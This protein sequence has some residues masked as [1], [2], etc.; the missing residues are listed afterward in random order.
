MKVKFSKYNYIFEKEGSIYIYNTRSSAKIILNLQEE[1]DYF[2]SIKDKVLELDNFNRIYYDN[3]ILVDETVDE[4]KMAF[5]SG[6]QKMYDTSKLNLIIMPTR[7]CDLSCIYCYEKHEPKYMSE[8]TVI[9]VIN[10]IKNHYSSTKFQYLNIEWFGGEPLLAI[11]IVEQITIAL[12]KFCNSNNIIYY[13]SITTNGYSM[14]KQKFDKL[15]NLGIKNYQITI[16]GEK[17]IHDKLRITKE[18]YGSWDKIF[19]TFRLMK[20]SNYDFS[21]TVRIN[22]DM[23]VLMNLEK[24]IDFLNKQLLYDDRFKLL[25]HSIGDYGDSLDNRLELITQSLHSS[26]TKIINKML[27]SKNVNIEKHCAAMYCY[28]HKCYAS[29]Q[30]SLVIDYDGR[31]HKCT[32]LID[33]DI[34]NVGVVENNEFKYNL[35]KLYKWISPPIYEFN[36][37]CKTCKCFPTCFGGSCPISYVKMG[38]SANTICIDEIDDE[39]MK[40]ITL[41]YMDRK[42]S[43]K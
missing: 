21:C 7:N 32:V 1:I 30:D 31:L 39:V 16:D 37:K 24:F 17:E 22:Y 36:R 10:A 27:I 28:G 26:T 19:N 40:D 2:K 13:A 6:C 25:V 33:D 35:E 43:V 42:K 41:E 3:G 38:D 14:D 9:Q 20:N 8:E 29:R 34:N 4:Y 5:V 23:R 12:R 18:G 15:I 11:D